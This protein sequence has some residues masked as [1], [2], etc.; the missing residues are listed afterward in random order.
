LIP[1]VPR[2]WQFISS[3][4]R[5]NQAARAVEALSP[6]TSEQ[7]AHAG[8]HYAAGL[9]VT[10]MAGFK[11]GFVSIYP[12]DVVVAQRE[13]AWHR[14][15][16]SKV[17][18][19]VG[20]DSS[21]FPD[22]QISQ[23]LLKPTVVRGRS[24][25]PACARLRQRPDAYNFVTNGC[26]VHAVNWGSEYNLAIL[27]ENGLGGVPCSHPECI[28]KGGQWRTKVVKWGHKS[29]APMIVI[30]ENGRPGPM[31]V[32]FS[33]C[34]DCI[35]QSRTATAFPHVHP[36]VLNRLRDVPELLLQLPFDPVYQFTDI[37][38]HRQHTR[39]TLACRLS[40][41]LPPP[42]PCCLRLCLF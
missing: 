20:L 33:V 3:T 36:V 28:G 10:D 8:I 32:A 35:E 15:E 39:C 42:P 40:H 29:R 17:M 19:G 14:R 38:L 1:I 23:K 9:K 37:F 2:V 41:L 34:E 12:K 31:D 24:G 27:E 21:P 22:G 18:R 30:D 13:A 4:W 7:A 5:E 6:L 16:M 26:Y 25:F 11:A